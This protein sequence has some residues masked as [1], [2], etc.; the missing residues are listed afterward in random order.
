[1]DDT[2][3]EN[4]TAYVGRVFEEICKE[5]LITRIN[6]ELN[7]YPLDFEN[8]G[9]WWNR[10]GEEIDMVE[11]N[12]KTRRIL[13]GE[14]KWT[15]DS[16]D[17]GVVDDLMRKSKFIGFTGEYK[18]LFISKNGFTEKASA[19]IKEINAILLSLKDIEKLF[20]EI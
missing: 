3:K 6:K 9:S 4:L 12:Q 8:I 16:V 10:T 1:M 5:L 11:Y 14:V 13:V 20:D 7:G 17:I 15:N 18:F 19:R 2:I